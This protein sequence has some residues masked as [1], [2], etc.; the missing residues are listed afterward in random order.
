MA[1]ALEGKMGDN[2]PPLPKFSPFAMGCTHQEVVPIS[3]PSESEWAFYFILAKIMM[4]V[5][6]KSRLKKPCSLLLSFGTT[7]NC[8]VRKH[9]MAY[10]KVRDM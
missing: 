3:Q 5:S 10:W 9:G 8:H 6:S 7:P 1:F 4:D 2:L